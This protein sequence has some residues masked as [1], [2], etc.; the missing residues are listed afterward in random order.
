[1]KIECEGDKL[2][3]STRCESNKTRL[4]DKRHLR[5]LFA[6][7]LISLLVISTGIA[8]LPVVTGSG[9]R[10]YL[11][12]EQNVFY[13][14]EKKVGD[15][16]NATV[17]V[18]NPQ[19]ANVSAFNVYMTFNDT[20]LAVTRWYEPRAD[21]QYIFNGRTT[22]SAPT[23]PDP[24][25]IHLAPGLG[26]VE[27]CS[28][29]FPTDQPPNSNTAKLCIFEFNITAAPSE[30]N[31]KL[32]SDLRIGFEDT[33]LLDPD[34][35]EI[36]GVAKEDGYYELDFGAPNHDVA[37][38]YV[39]PSLTTAVLGD[40][41]RIYAGVINMGNMIEECQV[42][43]YADTNTTIIGDEIIIANTSLVL[44]LT[45]SAA[46]GFDWNTTGLPFE[47]LTI[48]AEVKISAQDTN[49]TNNLLVDGVVQIVPRTDDVAV[50]GI[51]LS[52][53]VANFGEIVGVQIEVSNIGNVPEV[54]NVTV[55]ADAN[56]TVIGDELAIGVQAVSLPRETSIV[57]YFSWDTSSARLGSFT[58]SAKADIVQGDTNTTNNLRVG[59]SLQLMPCHD[60]A[61][62]AIE[63][64][65]SLVP[66]GSVVH[67]NV[68]VKNQGSFRETFNLTASVG[69]S[70][71]GTEEVTLASGSSTIVTFQWDTTGAFGVYEIMV[72]A[73]QVAEEEDVADNESTA[74][75]YVYLSQPP[76]GG[77]IF[78][79]PAEKTL[80]ANLT[81]I[82]DCFNVTVLVMNAHELAAWQVYME[83]NDSILQPTRW[84]E[85]TY[86]CSYIFHDRTTSAWPPPPD[87]DYVHLSPG[88]GRIRLAANL[89]PTP[90]T[91]SPVSGTGKLCIIEFNVTAVPGNEVKLSGVFSIDKSDTY[92]L[93]SDGM[94][95]PNITKENGYY[96]IVNATLGFHDIAISGITV[97][98]VIAVP[99][100]KVDIQVNV[101]NCGDLTEYTA[102]TVYADA[103]T[104][105]IGDEKLIGARNAI[106]TGNAT[107]TL[108][109]AWDTST[110]FPGN[111]TISAKAQ[112]ASEE[113][114]TTNNLLTDGT[115]QIA[116]NIHDVAVEEVTSLNHVVY[117]GDI[118]LIETSIQ[119][120]GNLNE[121]VEVTVYADTN[122][123]VVGDEV[124]V[125]I[126]NVTIGRYSSCTVVFDWNTSGLAAGNYTLTAVVSPVPEEVD[127][128]DNNRTGDSVQLFQ[129]VPCTDVS[130][131]CPS[132][133]TVNPSIFNYDGSH[134]ARI[135][136][137]GNVS[138]KSTGFAGDL[139][140]V[141]SVNGTI[142]LCL[143]QPDQDVYG[144]YLP[145]DGE[146]EVP[147]WLMFGYGHVY[148]GNYSLSLI[149]CGTHRRQLTV[150]N[151]DINICGNGVMI[152]NSG[153]V[154]FTWNLTGGSLV[155]LEAETDL[156]PGWN[157]TV[158]PPIGTFFET[159]HPI[160]VN[161][162]AP[163]DAQEG[164]MGRV[165]LR[166][167]K[168]STGQMIW[169][170]IYF[171]STDNKPP[172]I[173]S[174]ETPIMTPDG[175]LLFNAT[176]RDRSGIADVVLHCSVDGGP[177][178]N[179]TMQW[180]SGDTFNSTQYT[181]AE[182][183][184]TDAKTIQ[185]YISTTDWLNN[186]TI[187]TTQT[188]SITNDI[189]VSDLKIDNRI[190]S[191]MNVVAMNVTVTNLGSLPLSFASVG[192]YVN[193]TLTATLSVD[194]LNVGASTSLNYSLALPKGTYIIT[195]FA[196]CLPS[197]VDTANNAKAA[198][199]YYHGDVSADSV[200]P[201]KTVVDQGY[202][203][204]VNVT[205]TNK[206]SF[207]E[208]FKV[209]LYANTTFVE[210]QTV[211]LSGGNT[212]ILVLNWNTTEF[213]KGNY[214]MSVHAWPVEG[215]TLMAD[216][217]RTG[218]N[219][220]VAMVG[221]IN[222]DGK[223]DIKDVYA[224]ARAYGTSLQGPDPPGR[225]YSPNC[226]INNDGYIEMKDYY[227]VCKHYGET[228]P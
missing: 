166:A 138:I 156:P 174:V 148:S 59:P 129:A 176:V 24:G 213:D 161:I 130:V 107:V 133:L 143:N 215:E 114:N 220:T 183:V 66:Q 54:F 73:D 15:R 51:F 83:F 76:T 78:L 224:V 122:M 155:Y 140:V 125:G 217:T 131:T 137:I 222:A 14:S 200:V 90:P 113:T 181:L 41:V 123:T 87:P 46:L 63:L 134:Q 48:S 178:Q 96:E 22:S 190:V 115:I 146:V 153:T 196:A 47:S 177:W 19:E 221:D 171:A 194:R 71:I 58:V 17:W 211:T 42:C 169:Q 72:K 16:F 225:R 175:H 30:P 101:T 21:P 52:K 180:A 25:Y 116:P 106:V 192:I 112:I 159:P 149:V 45:D 109:F 226:D 168:N 98:R 13:V 53:Q 179:V 189:A 67:L 77:I 12:P 100:D 26:R 110:A 79:F 62:I 27:I 228:Y 80:S 84:F 6:A 121:N 82:G 127:L 104:T 99:G 151:I 124:V 132:A 160:S 8:R 118:A 185:Y 89:F 9:L 10:I 201:C 105:T 65:S 28:F 139:R 184:G 223:V 88:K 202:S 195:A 212:T 49:L 154:T 95:I 144:F 91:Q 2:R 75:E 210:E 103:N 141:G 11:D 152:H 4:S 85:P 197:E 182:Y 102:V 94:E 68:T 57:L 39:Y 92:L 187:S 108:S 163:S 60:V 111:L 40:V 117:T 204:H 219:V 227:V 23:P 35:N 188:I 70:I 157:Y 199:L 193:S 5:K 186:Q 136:N 20:I 214:V 43:V 142:R 44:H 18:E 56:I 167:Y 61:V 173:E 147:I 206:G 150:C 208:T 172:T 205:V 207:T 36:G 31:S 32:T 216:N 164:D 209:T 120:Q 64:A 119:N 74:I 29:L 203:T 1:V 37:V 97:S 50:T 145:L 7:L 198:G 81:H 162:T 33:F 158:D 86:D 55:Y 126:K 165:T 38:T 135:M 218:G 34:G 93:D 3:G 128:E 191:E 69:A 170:F